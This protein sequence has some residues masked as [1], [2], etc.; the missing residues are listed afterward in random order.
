MTEA[1]KLSVN[2]FGLFALVVMLLGIFM[3]TAETRAE[4]SSCGNLPVKHGVSDGITVRNIQTNEGCRVARRVAK[5]WQRKV[6]LNQCMFN[7]NCIARRFVCRDFVGPTSRGAY[8]ILCRRGNTWT[9]WFSK[10]LL[11][12]D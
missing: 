10:Q 2:T 11:P 8:G 12:P 9:N 3:M 6:V 5:Q 4:A 7:R 1:K